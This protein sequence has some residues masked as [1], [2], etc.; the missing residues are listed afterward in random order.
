MQQW[1]ITYIAWVTSQPGIIITGGSLYKVTPHSQ[2]PIKSKNPHTLE[3][4][5]RLGIS[6]E[7]KY[8]H[9]SSRS[10]FRIV[11]DAMISV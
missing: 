7:L 6:V 3:P 9:Q 10:Q 11:A 5:L 1:I 2:K 8:T 4:A